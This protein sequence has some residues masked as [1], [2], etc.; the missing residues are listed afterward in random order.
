MH[1]SQ[2]THHHC[3]ELDFRVSTPRQWGITPRY[4][5]QIREKA[6]D[7]GQI[8][9]L[10]F[11]IGRRFQGN[12]NWREVS[13]EVIQE[14]GTKDFK[15]IF[16]Q[17][18]KVARAAAESAKQF[19]KSMKLE[20]HDMQSKLIAKELKVKE[21]NS[22]LDNVKQKLTIER[23]Q[24]QD[25]RTA[26]ENERVN[27]AKKKRTDYDT[28]SSASRRSHLRQGRRSSKILVSSSGTSVQPSLSKI[29][30]S[31][32]S[33]PTDLEDCVQHLIGNLANE[34]EETL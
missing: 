24:P 9:W 31:Q 28:Y 29:E 25:I 11:A 32:H 10:G 16:D 26:V 5:K 4:W 20:V 12:Q 22:E 30:R 3:R 23:A 13:R 33:L 8:H 1:Y 21:V 18:V 19:R 34:D 17:S 15:Q 14:L 27:V 2:S 6:T 7:S